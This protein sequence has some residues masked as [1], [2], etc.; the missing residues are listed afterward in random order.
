MSEDTFVH[1]RGPFPFCPEIVE[2]VSSI[3]EQIAQSAA[4]YTGTYVG[5]VY[6]FELTLRQAVTLFWRTKKINIEYG[7]SNSECD[8]SV[9]FSESLNVYSQPIFPTISA[10]STIEALQQ[11]VCG[12]PYF[13]T[14][15]ELYV[16]ESLEGGDG[17]TD[18]RPATIS[19]FDNFL[20]GFVSGLD[21]GAGYA[22]GEIP[23]CLAIFQGGDPQNAENYLY[24]PSFYFTTGIYEN[25]F[26][27]FSP[28]IYREFANGDYVFTSAGE[29]VLINLT[30]EGF[31]L[32]LEINQIISTICT[33]TNFGQDVFC[34]SSGCGE[35]QFND[36]EIELWPPIN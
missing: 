28:L 17:F 12:E 3:D 20:E 21:F 5:S 16:G 34:Q 13:L 7:L 11:R 18:Y 25:G 29:T 23:R 27:T 35:Y 36:W 8:S 14:Y 31:S 30:S 19:W 26:S 4:N 32:Q 33:L 1:L 6:P 15:E 24:Y 2:S 10:S 9:R 22:Q